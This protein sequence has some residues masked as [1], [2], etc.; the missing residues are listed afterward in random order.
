MEKP[1]FTESYWVGVTCTATKVWVRGSGGG[2]SQERPWQ[3]GWSKALRAQPSPESQTVS[4]RHR[5]EAGS[6]VCIWRRRWVFK[7]L[8]NYTRSQDSIVWAVRCCKEFWNQWNFSLVFASVDCL[9]P[10]ELEEVPFS[11]WDKWGP[12]DHINSGRDL[13][14]SMTGLQGFP[15]PPTLSPSFLPSFL[16]S[17]LSKVKRKLLYTPSWFWFC[18]QRP[19]VDSHGSQ[20]PDPCRKLTAHREV[21]LAS[22]WTPDCVWDHILWSCLGSWIGTRNLLSE[23]ATLGWGEES[24]LDK[25]ERSSALVCLPTLWACVSPQ[26]NTAGM[27]NFSLACLEKGPFKE[28]YFLWNNLYYNVA[29]DRHVRILLAIG[30]ETLCQVAMIFVLFSLCVYVCV[31]CY[32]ESEQR[33]HGS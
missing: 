6:P 5:T 17:F 22:G 31:W 4:L 23:K 16:W 18:L 11:R 9:Q 7:W 19:C 32:Q 14:F 8:E 13:I 33:T 10:G 1:G 26:Q 27:S 12:E 3:R 30:G 21:G 20:K 25:V 29:A 15:P 2:P 24:E 28:I